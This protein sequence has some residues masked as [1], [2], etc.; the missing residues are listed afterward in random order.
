MFDL[1][2]SFSSVA[3]LIQQLFDILFSF[4]TFVFN[5][6]ASIPVYFT[7][8]I[9]FLKI[10]VVELPLTL[11]SIFFELPVFVQTGLMIVIYAMYICFAMKLLK[12][13]LL[14]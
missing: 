5:F 3:D 7:S 8:L 4:I 13:L 6:I 1:I 11:L 9:D 14:N 2:R 12:L 10:Y